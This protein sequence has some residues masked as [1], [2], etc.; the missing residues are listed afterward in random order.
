MAAKGDAYA[1]SV[2]QLQPGMLADD[3][4]TDE[5]MAWARDRLAN[6]KCPRSIDYVDEIPRSAAGKV[7]RRT[8][9]AAYWDD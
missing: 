8:V 1:V 7:Q 9:R 2:V 4:L 6:F 3:S 5:L